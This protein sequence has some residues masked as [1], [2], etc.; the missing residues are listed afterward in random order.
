MNYI[1]YNPCKDCIWV[2][3]VIFAKLKGKLW[4]LIVKVLFPLESTG[5]V[6]FLIFMNMF[7]E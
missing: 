1:T 2:N 3:N 6:I 7:E 5:S 4:L